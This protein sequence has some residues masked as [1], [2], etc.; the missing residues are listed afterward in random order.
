MVEFENRGNSNVLLYRG[1]QCPN[2]ALLDT[3]E[4][5]GFRRV[6]GARLYAGNRWRP[7]LPFSTP[8]EFVIKSSNRNTRQRFWMAHGVEMA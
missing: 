2:A 3:P 1:V 6:R 7:A 4:R 5:E 8:V